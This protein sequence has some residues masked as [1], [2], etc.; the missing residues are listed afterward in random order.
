MSYYVYAYLRNDGTPY[1]IGKG[2]K[3]RAFQR[4]RCDVKPPKDKSKII[5]VETNLTDIGA[6]AIERRLIQWYGRKDNNTGI[7]R[8][9]TDGGEG[10]N[11]L[12]GN[13]HPMKR[14]SVK[15]KI[16]GNNHFTK[17]EGYIAVVKGKKNPK[18]SK[19]KFDKKI[20]CW[21]NKNT[22][23]IVNLTRQEFIEN[24]GANQSVVSELIN[25]KR[26]RKSVSGWSLVQ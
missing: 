10:G 24:Y 8:N 14:I 23:Q 17:R 6:C 5:F 20:Y 15:E 1:Y 12:S 2:T 16:S 4:N 18:I 11:G 13:Q 25:Q 19:A 9:R 3:Q 21:Q 26:N 7:L 22:G